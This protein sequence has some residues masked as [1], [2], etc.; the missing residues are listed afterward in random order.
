MKTITNVVQQMTDP[1][2]ILSALQET[3]REIDPEFSNVEKKY[4]TACA[5]L[6]EALRDTSAP[7]VGAYLAAKEQE[8]ALEIIYI[9]WQ[10]FRLNMDIFHDPVHALLL[11]G[12]Y[13]ELL[14]ERYLGTLPM[15]A[16]SRSTLNAF[17][18]EVR[19]LPQEQ[20]EMAEE[21]TGFYAYLETTGYKIAHYFG[22][23][24]ADHFLHHIIPGYTSDAVNTH[25]YSRRLRKDLGIDLNA[26]E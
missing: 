25:R 24:L 13:E 4:L 18:A 15:P 17:C 7:S 2:S 9:V 8:T 23:R 26:M 22:F 14:R 20:Q 1:K 21:I 19:T 11:Q 16:A 12:D 6:E 10:G 3:L 5:G